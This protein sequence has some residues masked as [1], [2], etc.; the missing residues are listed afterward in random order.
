MPKMQYTVPECGRDLQTQRHR[1]LQDGFDFG[2][3]SSCGQANAEFCGQEN[4][5]FNPRRVQVQSLR[6]SIQE[7]REQESPLQEIPYVALV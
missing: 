4:S 7:H 6:K 3:I 5:I 1:T 2:A